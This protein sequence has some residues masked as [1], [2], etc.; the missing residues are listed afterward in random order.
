MISS[1]DFKLTGAPPL[2]S[3]FVLLSIIW[4]ASTGR[5]HHGKETGNQEGDE[6]QSAEGESNADSA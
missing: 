1:W 5:R 4:A 2:L 3:F 6:T